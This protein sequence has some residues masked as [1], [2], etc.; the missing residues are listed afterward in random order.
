MT[1]LSR[2]DWAFEELD[3]RRVEDA[4]FPQAPHPYSDE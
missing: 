1:D 4:R 3:A 2:Q